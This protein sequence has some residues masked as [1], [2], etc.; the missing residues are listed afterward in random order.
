MALL[1]LSM[2]EERHAQTHASRAEELRKG[3]NDL[4]L[5]YQTEVQGGT[6]SL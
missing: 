4:S 2:Q 5:P 6:P 1:D 3:A